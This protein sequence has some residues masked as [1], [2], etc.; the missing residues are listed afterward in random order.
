MSPFGRLATAARWL[1][2]RSAVRK[3]VCPP[4]RAGSAAR[5]PRRR[6]RRA[7]RDLSP[8]QP[9][10]RAATLGDV[11][12]EVLS[13]ERVN[14]FVLSGFAAIALLIAVVGVAGVPGFS[15]SARPRG[16]GARAGR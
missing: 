7:P 10:A 12:A 6:P 1:W 13:P 9:R 8:A 16:V 11:R 14:A 3:R 2:G 4:R 5:P 15:G